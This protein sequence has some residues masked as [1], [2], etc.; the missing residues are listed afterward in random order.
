VATRYLIAAPG[1]WSD[2]ASWSEEKNGVGGA[3][4]PTSADRVYIPA[5]KAVYLDTDAEVADIFSDA[6]TPSVGRILLPDTTPRTLTSAGSIAL[7]YGGNYNIDVTA[8]QTLT[9]NGD[10]E[11]YEGSRSSQIIHVIGGT[12]YSNGDWL[13]GYCVRNTGG[14]VVHVGD[15]T[16]T[17]YQDVD[18]YE[19]S[20]G[21]TLTHTGDM[22]GDVEAHMLRIH[23]GTATITGDATVYHGTAVG[24]QEGAVATFIGDITLDETRSA[25]EAPN[26]PLAYAYGMGI[27]ELT[28]STVIHYGDVTIVKGTKVIR[29]IAGVGTLY[30]YGNLSLDGGQTYIPQGWRGAQTS[31]PVVIVTR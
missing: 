9:I 25:T 23:G 12:L 31:D 18:L 17:L 4:V 14:T 7:V 10:L 27:G 26:E 11:P 1:N 20:E 19:Q 13:H 24:V 15:I 16:C 5:G 28:P 2:T 8:G 3:S 30:H 29:S 22:L 6:T 21:A